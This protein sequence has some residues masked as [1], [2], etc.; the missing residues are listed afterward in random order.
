MDGETQFMPLPLR[1][2]SDRMAVIMIGFSEDERR[3]LDNRPI[4]ADDSVG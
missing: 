4:R 3:G 1:G 2:M